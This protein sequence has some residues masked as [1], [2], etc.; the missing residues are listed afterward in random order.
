MA[1]PS[2]I[3]RCLASGRSWNPER[4]FIVKLT[5]V[6]MKKVWLNSKSQCFGT[7]KL[8]NLEGSVVFSFTDAL[9][10]MREHQPPLTNLETS[11]WNKSGDGRQLRCPA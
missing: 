2:S 5:S 11:V 1:G 4:S 7:T 9:P 10:V 3:S 8:K 6:T